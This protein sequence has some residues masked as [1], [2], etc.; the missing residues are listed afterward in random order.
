MQTR[1]LQSLPVSVLV[2]VQGCT[3]TSPVKRL[4]PKQEFFS[5]LH[6]CVGQD[7]IRVGFSVLLVH[8]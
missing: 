5:Q 2:D 8:S 3:C 7:T 4:E 1:C 6:S